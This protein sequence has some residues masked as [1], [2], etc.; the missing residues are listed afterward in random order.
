MSK[1]KI[2]IIGGGWRAEF[3]VR[4]ARELSDIFEIQYVLFRDKQKSALFKQ[5]FGIDTRIKTTLSLDELIED[6]PDYVILSLPRS[7]SLKYIEK[8]FKHKIAILCETPP[9]DGIIELN[10]LWQLYN[11]YNGK[12]QVAEQYFLQPLYSALLNV[13]KSGLLG[14]ISN[15]NISALHGYHAINI[16][17]NFLGI[18]SENCLIYGK[19]H[20]IDVV[21]TAGR[22]GKC[23]TGE[24]LNTVRS[25][26]TF[27]FENGKL[28]FFDFNAQQYHP[29]IRTRHI[30]IQGLRG[31]IDDLIIR[32]LNDKNETVVQNLYRE[33]MGI[34]N[35]N[36]PSHVGIMLG[37]K[38]IYKNPFPL[39]RLNDD[40]IAIAT[41]MEMMKKYVDTGKEFYSFKEALQDSY[42]AIML[43]EALEQPLCP[44]ETQTQSWYM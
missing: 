8:L 23:L 2:S 41:C 5:K 11:E 3:F 13:S 19:N 36:G 18:I 33:D 21:K 22:E 29:Y 31:E 12:I 27:E 16:I 17:R 4:I 14:D 30:N 35:F 40:E 38:Y 24:V 32:Y 39:A 44:L 10:K 9:A 7:A 20:N 42:L 26:A 15:I 25:R 1:I 43:E 37:N 6:N 34:Y 28:A